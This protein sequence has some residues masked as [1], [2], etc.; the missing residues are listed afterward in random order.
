MR[1]V[2]SPDCS[3]ALDFERL[4]RGV[5]MDRDT[6]RGILSMAKLDVLHA[7]VIETARRSHPYEGHVLSLARWTEVLEDN[8]F[9]DE[10]NRR[11]DTGRK[12]LFGGSANPSEKDYE[13][14]RDTY[15]PLLARWQLWPAMRAFF[16]C[17][18]A[19]LQLNQTDSEPFLSEIVADVVYEELQ[20][21]VSRGYLK[22]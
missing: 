15:A 10:C 11:F 17:L 13:E 1:R 4:T 20:D 9:R 2:E 16:F 19:D 8:A 3:I 21:Q 22:L 18:D 7:A 12:R 14:L 6:R 5:G